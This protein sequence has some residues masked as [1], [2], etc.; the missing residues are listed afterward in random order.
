MLPVKLPIVLVHGGLYEGMTTR[1]FW[2]DTGVIGGLRSRHL[3]HLAPQ[4]PA[5]PQ[6]WEE[7]SVSLLAAI[8]EAGFERVALIGAS[9]GCSAATR[10]AIDHP[11]RVER[12]M[13]AWPA[14]AG[15]RVVDEL[16]RVIITDETG[17]EA[18]EALLTGETLRGVS[19]AELAAVDLP[20]VVYPS[21]LENQVH[22]RETLMGILARVTDAFMVQGSPEPPDDD[23]DGFVDAFVTMVEEFGRVEHDD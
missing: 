23:F 15:D 7:E 11:D 2:E 18:A 8:D 13:L 17:A 5:R 22:Q 4:R 20:V 3:L 10:F 9:N 12:L 6:S 14:T 16:L 1:E 19:D 21:L